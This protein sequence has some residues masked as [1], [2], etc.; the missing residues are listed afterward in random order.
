MRY[1]EFEALVSLQRLNRYRIAC[2]YNIRKTLCLYRANIRMSQA[3]L[4]VLGIFEVVLRNRIDAHYK[5]QFSEAPD[6]F[7]TAMRP[8]G[9]LTQDGCQSSLNKITQACKGL[10][11]SYSHD[12]LLSQLSFGFWKFMFAGGQFKAGGGKPYPKQ[13]GASRT[14][15]FWNRECDRYDLCEGCLSGNY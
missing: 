12:K 1:A 7:L 9:F 8:G 15:L 4:A 6:W 2:N 11:G 5:A 13:S 10:G 3:F 14:Y